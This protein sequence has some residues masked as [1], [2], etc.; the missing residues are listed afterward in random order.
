MPILGA[1]ICD[2]AALDDKY[3]ADEMKF[4]RKAEKTCREHEAKEE[5]SMYSQLLPFS[6]PELSE[7]IGKRIDVLCSFDINVKKGTK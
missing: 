7:L 2:V 5:G 1:Q 3:I 4:K 6:Q